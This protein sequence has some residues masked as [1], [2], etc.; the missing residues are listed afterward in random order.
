MCAYHVVDGAVPAQVT[1]PGRHPAL[2]SGVVV[3]RLP[4]ARMAGLLQGK[5]VSKSSK[6]QKSGAKVERTLSKVFLGLEKLKDG[7]PKVFLALEKLKY[8]ASKVFWAG[9][10]T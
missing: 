7:R 8:T 10:K 1:D 5:T 6:V 9:V 4:S 2:R 3:I